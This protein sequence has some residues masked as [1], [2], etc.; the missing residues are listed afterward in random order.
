MNGTA[1]D[2]RPAAIGSP[3]ETVEDAPLTLDAAAALMARFGFVA[4]RT[5]PESPMPDSCLMAMLRNTPTFVHFDPMVMTYWTFEAGHGR[6]ASIDTTT[7][8]PIS[9]RVSWGRLEVR[10]RLDA[11]NSFVSLGGQLRAE[12]V[13]EDAILV[14]FHSAAPILRLS[15]HSQREDEL[16]QE[17]LGF[18]ARLLPHLWESPAMEDRLAQTQPDALWGAFL[19]DE[20]DRLE[21]STRATEELAGPTPHVRRALRELAGERPAALEAGRALLKELGLRTRRGRA[22]AE[23]HKGGG[24]KARGQEG[25]RA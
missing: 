20:L 19:V 9:R 6:P 14:V 22:T 4:F 5:P 1:F 17:V 21:G 12:R 3:P 11:R 16:A 7:P 25:K 13:G 8:V 2:K 23:A 18:F 24:A 15:G 10:D